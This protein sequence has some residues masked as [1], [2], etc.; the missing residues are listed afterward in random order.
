MI[1]SITGYALDRRVRTDAAQNLPSVEQ[2]TGRANLDAPS[3]DE[4]SVPLATDLPNRRI[5]L[6]FQFIHTS[7]FRQVGMGSARYRR[8]GPAPETDQDLQ[9]KNG[10]YWTLAEFRFTPQM[11]GAAGNYWLPN[12]SINPLPFDDTDA[13]KRALA[14][15]LDLYFP[16]AG[17][18][19][20]YLTD[21][22]KTRPGHT[23]TAPHSVGST[24]I[25]V[26]RGTYLVPPV[27]TA[28]PGTVSIIDTLDQGTFLKIDGLGLYG[29]DK[30]YNGVARCRSRS[31]FANMHVIGCYVG[32]GSPGNYSNSGCYFLN[33]TVVANYI[34]VLN[35]IDSRHMG[36]RYASND[37]DGM[38]CN[39]GANDNV[40]IAVKLD[41]NGRHGFKAFGAPRQT[42][43][44]ENVDRNGERGLSIEAASDHCRIDV[45]VQRTGRSGL[46]TVEDCCH[47]YHSA[48]HGC[49]YTLR[50]RAGADDGGGGALGPI[51]SFVYAGT[52]RNLTVT[53]DLTGCTGTPMVAK[54]GA[55]LVDPIIIAQGVESQA[56]GL[57]P[58]TMRTATLSTGSNE[59][60]EFAM[61]GVEDF[62]GRTYELFV[63]AKRADNNSIMYVTRWLV[64][65]VRGSGA[66]TI[67]VLLDKESLANAIATSG[68]PTIGLV[69]VTAANN[70]AS[71]A[72]VNIFNKYTGNARFYASWR[73]AR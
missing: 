53:G 17:Y 37:L 73:R 9:D 67:Q 4:V 20:G 10:Q 36:G 15:T 68:T 6:R 42:V 11:F 66:T 52:S 31:T 57:S 40:V 7:G 63:E 24:D 38:Q 71:L 44:T 16:N 22:Q 51:A 65:F 2:E 18:R 28:A 21:T 23:L 55:L 34:G 3:L 1:I 12:G 56:P 45:F 43:I 32:F 60:L 47:V 41:F 61:P 33:N 62:N 46:T 26:C 25:L 30:I 27:S 50:T 70:D 5:P 49:I 72:R 29:R 39:T 14:F 48:S 35:T 69:T 19:T 13:I 59:T 58:S 54:S 64:T 8:A